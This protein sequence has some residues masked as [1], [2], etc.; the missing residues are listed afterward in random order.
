MEHF[1]EERLSLSSRRRREKAVGL[2]LDAILDA[3]ISAKVPAEHYP[4]LEIL[5]G[6]VLTKVLRTVHQLD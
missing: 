4:T 6:P 3:F 1:S 2:I 5:K